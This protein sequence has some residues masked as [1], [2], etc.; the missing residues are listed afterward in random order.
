M[1]ILSYLHRFHKEELAVTATEYAVMLAVIIIGVLVSLQS[2]GGEASE[3][4]QRGSD[5]LTTSPDATP[6]N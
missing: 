3:T 4:F 6:V 1:K 5:V 2:L